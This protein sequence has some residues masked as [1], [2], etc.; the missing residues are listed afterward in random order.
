MKKAKNGDSKN[1]EKMGPGPI[2]SILFILSRFFKKKQAA[3][4]FFRQGVLK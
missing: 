4:L 3:P 2:F 1:V